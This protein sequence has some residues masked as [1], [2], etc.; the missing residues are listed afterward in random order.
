MRMID[1][2]MQKVISKYLP[3][4]PFLVLE[5]GVKHTRIRNLRSN[6]WLP[7]SGSSSDHRA[8]KNFES[9]LRCLAN[10]GQGFIFSKT[11]HLPVH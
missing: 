11:G 8:V 2:Q 1:K 10:S 5:E 6:D 4:V 7:V 9:S 3:G